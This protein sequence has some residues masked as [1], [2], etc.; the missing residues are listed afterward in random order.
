MP[1]LYPGDQQDVLDLGVHAFRLSRYAGAWVGLKIVTSVADGIGTVDLDPDRHAPSDPTDLDDRRRAAGATSRWRTVGPHAVPGPG[2]AGRRPPA[3]GGPGL[4]PPQRPRPGRRRRRRARRL[5]IVCAGKTYFDVVQ[6][7]A[8]LGVSLDDLAALGVRVLKL[9]MTYPLVDRDGRS[10]SPASVDELRGRSRRSGRS[11]RRSCA[12]S[13]TR[14]GSPV[15]VLGQARPRRRAAGVVG[16][17]ARRRPRSAP[18]SAGC[19]PT[20]AP[21]RRAAARRSAAAARASPVAPPGFCSGCP[22]NR[23][24]VA[25]GRRAGRRRRRL[26]RDHVL[27]GPP[28]RHDEPAAHADGRRG[29]AVDRPG[30]VRRRAPPDPEHRRRHP[31]PL[32]H[33]RHPGQRR[34]RRRTSPSR[35]STTPRSP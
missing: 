32:G 25:P 13:C 9:A 31:Q 14:R 17:R 27:R 35:S 4:R 5:G 29:R 1:V 16:R 2:G 6:A 33:P 21:D 34:G 11:S 15:P 7:F 23:S 8:D 19:C 18:S 20:L 26:P 12:A 10:S 24:T 3:A 28:R 30:P 22:H